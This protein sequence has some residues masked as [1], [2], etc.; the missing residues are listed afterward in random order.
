META[1]NM[2]S[3]CTGRLKPHCIASVSSDPLQA[4]RMDDHTNGPYAYPLVQRGPFD[5]TPNYQVSPLGVN[6]KRVVV[7]IVFTLLLPVRYKL[8]FNV[9]TEMGQNVLI[10]RII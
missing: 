7:F 2:R 10:Y 4:L 6:M 1:L 3:A 8:I 5:Y 9:R